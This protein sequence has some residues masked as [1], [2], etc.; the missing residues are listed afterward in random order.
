MTLATEHKMCTGVAAA[1]TV[2]SWKRAAMPH[3]WEQVGKAK[4]RTVSH[5]QHTPFPLAEWDNPLP[6]GLA[7]KGQEQSKQQEGLQGRGTS[8]PSHWNQLYP[9]TPA[10][11]SVCSYT[12]ANMEK[13]SRL[14]EAPG[15]SLWETLETNTDQRETP[16]C[17]H[18]WGCPSLLK[19]D[20]HRDFNC[21]P[22]VCACT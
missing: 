14:W 18:S 17:I 10:G 1:A 2:R 7:K 9:V 11:F 16:S 13:S 20:R 4:G 6:R 19:R 21:K 22:F 12:A 3:V 8:A 15:S 5:P